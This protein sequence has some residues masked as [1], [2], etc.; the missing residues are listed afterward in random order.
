MTDSTNAIK[1][2]CFRLL[3]IFSLTQSVSRS[4]RQA[5]FKATLILL[6]FGVNLSVGTSDLIIVDGIKR[7]AVCLIER[8]ASHNHITAKF[9]RINYEQKN[10]GTTLIKCQLELGTEKYKAN[11]TSFPK[12]KEKVSRQ[13]YALT[14]YTKPTLGNRTC[15]ANDNDAVIVKS[16]ISLLEEYSHLIGGH[17]LYNEAARNSNGT[18]ECVASFDGK[19]AS[20]IGHKKR[21]AKAAAATHLLDLVGRSKVIGA[22]RNKYN[23]TG[24]HNMEPMSRLRKII[25]VTHIN[26]EG[27]YSKVKEVTENLQGKGPVKRIVAQ[28]SAVNMMAAGVGDTYDEACSNAAAKLLEGLNFTVTYHPNH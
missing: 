2:I 5:M 11:S 16:D 14:N 6:L 8:V 27:V 4:K 3:C 24:Y 1:K 25:S 23:A 22:L 17:V 13:A 28:V 9:E 18:F 26:G 19:S 7:S 12:A 20:G 15:I 21:D 10:N